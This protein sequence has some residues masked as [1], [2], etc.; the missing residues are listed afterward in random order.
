MPRNSRND[1]PPTA[2]FVWK[3]PF[4][5]YCGRWVSPLGSINNDIREK[6]ELCKLSKL[7]FGLRKGALCGFLSYPAESDVRKCKYTWLI[8]TLYRMTFFFLP[9]FLVSALSQKKLINSWSLEIWNT[10]T[11]L[12][13]FWQ[14]LTWITWKH[15]CLSPLGV[16]SF[17]N[18]GGWA[19][20]MIR[21]DMRAGVRGSQHVPMS[22]ALAPF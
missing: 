21:P 4:V 3:A 10:D 6:A 5:S 7:Q 11:A 14:K 2:C 13:L 8:S 20:Y 16:W 19:A 12:P 15:F 17:M 22:P 18:L 9:G 1:Q